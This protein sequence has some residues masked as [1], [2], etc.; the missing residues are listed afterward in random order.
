MVV[1]IPFLNSATIISDIFLVCGI[2][3]VGVKLRVEWLIIKL[4]VLLLS[5]FILIQG[6]IEGEEVC[7]LENIGDVDRQFHLLILIVSLVT[8][9][10]DDHFG[11]FIGLVFVVVQNDGLRINEGV[12]KQLFSTI[13]SIIQIES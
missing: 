11:V 6:E 9:I 10:V 7:E 8:I 2:I 12:V 5:H 1:A 4:K 3:S 13:K